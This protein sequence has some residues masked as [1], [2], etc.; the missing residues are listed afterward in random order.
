MT[1]LALLSTALLFGGMALYAFG[2]AT[3]LFSN[4]PAGQA[5]RLLRRAFPQFY[6]F[7]LVF[8]SISALLLLSSDPI[9][10]LLLGCVA[11]TVVPA[12]QVLIPAINEATDTGQKRRF[13]FLHALSVAV[14]L[15]HIGMAAAVLS[16]FT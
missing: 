16:R 1:L 13:Q 8:S 11:A 5:G 15:A 9:G 4:L 12:R 7:V 10:A 6:L 2:F 14:T 3:F